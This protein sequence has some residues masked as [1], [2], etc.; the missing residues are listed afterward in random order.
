M[1]ARRTDDRAIIDGML[2]HRPKGVSASEMAYNRALHWDRR[3]EIA[4][5]W[6]ELLMA[7]QRPAADLLGG[8]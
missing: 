8:G 3:K 7:G 2:A 1:K 4:A 6:A 5:E